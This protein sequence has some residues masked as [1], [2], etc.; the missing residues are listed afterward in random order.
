MNDPEKKVLGYLN[1]DG[2]ANLITAAG[3]LASLLTAILFGKDSVVNEVV[4]ELTSKHV[5]AC[6]AEA[7]E[8]E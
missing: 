7:F 6:V 3:F 4:H 1:R 8:L 5:A 2:V